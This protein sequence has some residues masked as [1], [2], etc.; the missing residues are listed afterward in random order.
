[1]RPLLL[2]SWA[3][4][5]CKDRNPFLVIKGHKVNLIITILIKTMKSFDYRLKSQLRIAIDGDF[6]EFVFF[7]NMLYV[8]KKLCKAL[9]CLHKQLYLFSTNRWWKDEDQITKPCNIQKQFQPQQ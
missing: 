1:M 7:V 3:E 9:I 5:H 2:M 4:L 6:P 8:R